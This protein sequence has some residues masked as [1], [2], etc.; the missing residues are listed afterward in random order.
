M[1][2][3]KPSDEGYQNAVL[4][5]INSSELGRILFG[6][7]TL[8][9]LEQNVPLKVDECLKKWKDVGVE[10]TFVVVQEGVRSTLAS[11]QEIPDM[12]ELDEKRKVEFQYRTVTAKIEVNNLYEEVLARVYS[13]VKAE[14]VRQNV[15][16]EMPMEKLLEL[17]PCK[18]QL[19][20]IKSCAVGKA[21]C[22]EGIHHHGTGHGHD[23]DHDHGHDDGHDHGHD[24]WHGH[25]HDQ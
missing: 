8:K 16:V 1:I 3:G 4:Q 11:L 24:H 19:P 25:C 12:D 9:I 15:L 2:E 6:G 5:V 17:G 14:A 21:M 7:N 22:H 20:T 10:L 23:H 13:V 18:L